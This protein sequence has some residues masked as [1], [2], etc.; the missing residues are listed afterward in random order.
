MF[1]FRLSEGDLVTQLGLSA[2][3][4]Q[5]LITN[6]MSFSGAWKDERGPR[7]HIDAESMSEKEILHLM[8]WRVVL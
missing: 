6:L 3:E 1:E 2:D 8:N 5:W 4:V 7:R